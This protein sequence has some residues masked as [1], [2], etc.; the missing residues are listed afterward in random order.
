MN[1]H[2]D[3]LIGVDVGGTKTHL[4]LIDSQGARRDIVRPS[5]EW[6]NG[7]LFSDERNLI[8]LAS[9]I[10]SQALIGTI[11][12]V[13]IGLR[14]C[15]TEAE[16]QRA[17]DAVSGALGIS[18][19]IENDADLLAPA[20][21]MDRAIAMVVGTG[22][23]VSARD[24]AGARVTAD[25]HGWLLGD[26]GSG[27]GLV[28]DALIR[29]LAAMDAGAGPGDDPLI[30]GLL[31][32]HKAGSA[33]ELAASATL[34]ASPDYWG[35]AAM[36]VFEADQAGSALAGETIGFAAQR[37]ADNVAAV[38][39]RGGL[40][41]HVVAAGGV[42]VNQPALRREVSQ[43]LNSF[44]PPLELRI[45]DVPPVEGALRLAALASPVPEC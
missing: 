37:L 23:I 43:R 28:R 11:T 40:G 21:G 29:T 25:G 19:R 15:D 30:A 32:H 41:D 31:A 38:V 39:N 42:I 34:A 16:L 26:W 33:A 7:H 1:R 22:S 6:R 14:D 3:R 12:S 35:S 8:R 24:A 18:V 20:M 4:A 10:G 9:W 27:P 13:A 44:S 5:S 45:L 17:R 36:R 2:P